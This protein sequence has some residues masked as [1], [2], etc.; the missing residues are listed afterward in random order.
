MENIAPHQNV[1]R[2]FESFT[3][4]NKF[5]ISMEYCDK[6]DLSDYIKRISVLPMSMGGGLPEWKIWK[7]FIQICL[8]LDH[9]HQQ[10]IVH[11]DIK[12]SN[13]L[14]SGKDC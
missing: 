14:L 9:L 8:A 13:I 11:S 4:G 1:V 12:P 5:Y 3:F 6:G 7:F 10:R 2:F